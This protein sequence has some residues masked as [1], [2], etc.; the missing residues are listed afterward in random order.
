MPFE[1]SGANR[2]P[3]GVTPLMV[4]TLFVFVVEDEGLQQGGIA[5][6]IGSEATRKSGRN[7]DM[8]SCV[9]PIKIAALERSTVEVENGT[10][11]VFVRIVHDL[12]PLR[13]GRT[14]SCAQKNGRAMRRTHFEKPRND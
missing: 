4:A 10:E 1:D 6:D 2:R 14:H 11:A 13:C 9:V 7:H 5:P 8:S 12:S 3:E